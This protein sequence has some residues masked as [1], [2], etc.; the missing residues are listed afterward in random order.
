MTY[1]V[2]SDRFVR[3]REANGETSGSRIPFSPTVAG[4]R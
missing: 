1:G 2:D 3:A 4:R